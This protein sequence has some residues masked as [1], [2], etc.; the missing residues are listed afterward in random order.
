MKKRTSKRFGRLSLLQGAAGMS[1][2]A[3]ASR[4]SAA[5]VPSQEARPNIIF[6][7]A[8]DLGWGDLA[9]NGNTN[10]FTPNLDRLASEGMN[11]Y[12]F[13]VNNP[14]CSPSRV[15]LLTGNFPSRFG[16]HQHFASPAE[17]QKRGMPD[18]L[19]PDAV[20]LPKIL[21][22]AG[23]ATAHYGKW[24]LSLAGAGKE[25]PEYPAYGYDDAAVYAWAGPNTRDV[26]T[27]T[28]VESKKGQPHEREP[29]AYLTVAA[30]E[31]TL[32]FI[33]AHKHEP[34][35]I[36]LWIHETHTYIAARPEDRIPYKDVPE[37][38]QTYYS[39]VT[40]ADTQIG[41]VLRKLDELGLKDN[42]I[43]VF[44]SDNGPEVPNETPAAMT[45]YS[46][47]SA[48]GLKG[49]KRSLYSGGVNTPFLIRWPGKIPAGK[50][51]KTTMISAVDM[52]PTL[53]AAAGVK[54][55]PAGYQ[56]DGENMLPAM[57]GKPMDRSKPLFWKWN[58]DH[59]GNNWPA[60]AMRDGRWV[61]LINEDRSRIEL[62][63]V[64]TDR[65]QKNNLF[66]QEPERTK[67]M[68]AAVERWIETLPKTVPVRLTAG[69]QAQSA[70]A[71]SP[72]VEKVQ[73]IP[74]STAQ[75]PAAVR[76]NLFKKL[77]ADHDGSVSFAEFLGARQDDAAASLR[78]RYDS[79]DTDKDGTLTEQEFVS[80]GKK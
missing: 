38:E 74:V 73:K 35:F 70:P 23:Y 72:V 25:A 48:G 39:A 26:F 32:T 50:I 40:R 1:L 19:D 22:Q 47:G 37:P 65:D 45:Y 62:Y 27:G 75:G 28:S 43:V 69:G 51:D 55:L 17:N 9:V 10:I 76:T 2:L 54:Q 21:K 16:V 8:D 42:T 33:E 41:S 15:A 79:F 64:I 77:D 52:L 34:F 4:S 11:F 44:S 53:A 13:T 61:F 68:Q 29:S 49:Q 12:Q 7:Y 20:T 6:I 78:Q 30:V 56:S 46:R 60:Y 24:H 67:V 36:N 71:P 63:D 58:G 80:A 66:A 59:S 18:W 5:P 31:N 3:L 57:F 14:V